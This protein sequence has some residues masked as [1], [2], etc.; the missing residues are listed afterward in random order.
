M[1]YPIMALETARERNAHLRGT[2]LKTIEAL[3][4]ERRRTEATIA[5]CDRRDRELE[6]AIAKLRAS[7]PTMPE[8][9]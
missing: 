6:D 1:D 8:P 9:A 2:A 4:G 7:N 3:D 5:E